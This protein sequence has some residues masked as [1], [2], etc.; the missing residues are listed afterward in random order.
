[1][2]KMRIKILNILLA[3]F[4]SSLLSGQSE[5]YQIEGK[6]SY[7][8]SEH[9][10]VRFL[11]TADLNI[12][13]TLKLKQGNSL[14]PCL[15][16]SKKSTRST[17]CNRVTNCSLQ[18]EDVMVFTKSKVYNSEP[19]DKQEIIAQ[20]K[21]SEVVVADSVNSRSESAKKKVVYNQRIT[22]RLSSSSYSNISSLFGDRHRI[23]QRFSL[24]A[25]HINNSK[26]SL[27][28][29]INYRQNFINTDKSYD[30]KTK[31]F[32]LY[33]L[34]MKYDLDPSFSLT[35]G[36]SVNNKASSLGAIDGI[37]AEKHF[38]SFYVGLISGFRPD[39][40]EFGFNPKLF[41]NG[42]YGGIQS[43]GPLLSSH[44]T[45]G[46]LEQRNNG[47]IDRRYT[48]FQ[49]SS[50]FSSALSLF[51]SFE[52]DVFSNV[53][54]VIENKP[55]LTNLYVSAR[56]K[57]SRRFSFAISYDSR[58]RIIFYE[59]LKTEIEQL[60]DDD[61]PRQGIRFRVNIKPANYLFAGF[62]FSRRFQNSSE[63]KSNNINGYIKHSK[64]PVVGG[65]I[66]MNFNLN[67]SNYLES[68]I[69]SFVHS[70]SL[71]DHKLDVDLYYRKAVYTYSRNE[72]N[73]S[74]NYF[75]ADLSLQLSRKWRC[76]LLGE[77]ALRK[78]EKNYRINTKL[79]SRF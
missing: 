66:H 69:I 19:D 22:G 67:S 8:T 16:I 62:T 70:R 23:M 42:I 13:D 3:I 78:N 48:Y 68:R 20:E 17:M 2:I 52:M 25:E 51:G 32:R 24:N 56:Y 75:G 54:G 34:S 41:E 10:Y 18:L 50:S 53:N 12:G 21:L 36:R 15:I 63:N 1:M 37:Q 9:V 44:T 72:I 60:L 14:Q 46:I 79:S 27:H 58:K 7:F 45:L 55:R 30:G 59:T 57:F 43:S 38:G 39:I 76:S 40:V 6:V 5:T 49:H 26:L 31:F 61:Q 11:N 64:L 74:Q 28:S 65:S 35:L 4:F 71:V 73:D 33:S 47:A 77:Y 29:Y